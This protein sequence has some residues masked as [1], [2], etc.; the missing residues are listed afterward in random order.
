MSK[1]ERF[2]IV[3]IGAGPNGMTTAAYLAKCGLSVCVLEERT[4]CGGACETQ[5]PIPGVRIY[6]HAMLMYA[7]PA[8][9]FEQLE[10]H[11]YGFRMTWDPNFAANGDTAALACTDGW[12]PMSMQDKM[13]WAKLGGLLGSPPFTKELMR[14][15]FWCPPHPAEIEVTDDNVPYMQVYKQHQPDIYTHELREMTMLDLLDEHCDTEHFKAGMAFAAWASGAAGHWEGVAIPA[16]LCVQLLTMP[17]TGQDSIPR[18]GLHGYFHAI[19]RAAVHKGAVVRTCCPVDEIL[20][21]DGRAIGVRLRDTAAMGGRTIRANKAVIAA[22]DVHQVFRKMVG[23]KHLDPGF[24]QKVKDI[25][26]KNQT[27]YVSVFHTK[28]QLRLKPK[29][30]REQQYVGPNRQPGLG[31][32]PCDSREI[33]YE[34]VADVDGRKGQP[35]VPPERALWFQAPPQSFDPTDCQANYPPARGYISQAY[36]MAVTSPDYHTEGEDAPDKYKPEMDAYMRKAYSQMLD[37]LEDE[38]VIHHWSATG[39]D[40]EFRNTGIIGG[41]WCGSRHD[42]DQLWTNRPIPELARYRTPIDGL[43]HAHQTSGHPGGL[44]LMAI[45]YNLMH[46]LIEDG[47]AAPGDWWYASPWY[48]PQPGKISAKGLRPA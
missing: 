3:V 34:N 39:R 2:D 47:I 15:T 13:G 16:A 35:T 9:G 10:L 37:G 40:V 23:P 11:K 5:E 29:F 4:E 25:S 33:Y 42:E 32:Y 48:I 41:T 7:S 36:E 28:K 22:C 12:R 43:Y 19:H 31:I 27:L 38:N 17:N 21:E 24:I 44:C 6:P 30:E 1:D 45:P 26:L 18:G 14:A 46:I 8:P 20:I